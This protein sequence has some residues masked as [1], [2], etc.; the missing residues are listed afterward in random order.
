MSLTEHRSCVYKL[1]GI[2][3]FGNNQVK[4]ND[5]RK[6]KIDTDIAGLCGFTISGLLF[7]AA[8]LRSGDTF[9]LL[10]SVVWII[11]CIGWITALSRSR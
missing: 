4:G 10:G 9:S 5:I 6:M 8:A 1:L 7:V 3:H 11:S 2:E